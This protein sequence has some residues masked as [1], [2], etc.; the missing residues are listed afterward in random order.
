MKI[1][2]GQ[3]NAVPARG[4]GTRTRG[5]CPGRRPL[6]FWHACNGGVQGDLSR[7]PTEEAERDR[8]NTDP[9]APSQ[10]PGQKTK[11]MASGYPSRLPRLDMMPQS[12]LRA[13]RELR[14][15]RGSLPS[16]FRAVRAGPKS[17]RATARG[18]VPSPG[19]ALSLAPTR[20]FP[21]RRDPTADAIPGVCSELV[22]CSREACLD[23]GGY[24]RQG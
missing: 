9:C 18:G 14:K 7:V 2:G 11:Q 1:G 19:H 16:G 22:F 6:A 3:T 8:S 12:R 15:A 21:V 4:P 24:R 13:P 20:P 10:R 17:A 5:A 23:E